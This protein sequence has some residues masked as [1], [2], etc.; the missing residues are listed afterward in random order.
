MASA[1][2]AVAEKTLDEATEKPSRPQESLGSPQKLGDGGKLAFPPSA[3]KSGSVLVPAEEIK[4]ESA[5]VPELHREPAVKSGG[6]VHQEPAVKSDWEVAPWDQHAGLLKMARFD[7]RREELLRSG[8]GGGI[9][10]FLITCAFRR[11]KSA[12]S[13]A[14]SILPKYLPALCARAEGSE[15]EALGGEKA[16]LGGGV[17]G[18]VVAADVAD[19]GK[20]KGVPE[21]DSRGEEEGETSA[22]RQRTETGGEGA[23]LREK[24]GEAEGEKVGGVEAQG[25]DSGRR[26]TQVGGEEG[27]APKVA[28]EKE[29]DS[30]KKVSKAEEDASAAEDALKAGLGAV[31]LGSMGITFLALPEK[32][33][34]VRGSEV[35]CPVDVV[36]QILKDIQEKKRT[37]L[38]WCQRICPVQATCPTT[39][40]HLSATVQR[41]LA[42]HF[43]ATPATAVAAT[44][45]TPQAAA[46]V[47]AEEAHRNGSETATELADTQPHLPPVQ[48]AV[49][50]KKRGAEDVAATTKESAKKDEKEAGRQEGDEGSLGKVQGNGGEGGE[51]GKVGEGDL[52]LSRDVVIRTVADA[53][54]EAAGKQGAAAN[55]TDPEFAI[56]VEIVPLARGPPFCAVSILPRSMLDTKPRLAVKT[57]AASTGGGAENA[58]GNGSAKT[59]KND[60][61]QASKEKKGKGGRRHGKRKRG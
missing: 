33:K 9:Q 26:F 46:A 29:E 8:N 2:P 31:K 55:L 40:R 52:V 7:Y 58:G 56:V 53:V 51:E 50:F 11:E 5:L 12:T 49:A 19:V 13:E 6:D 44:T 10:G 14:L 20:G 16:G 34:C 43:A 60:S 4:S 48:F 47:G 3:V 21:G 15:A 17:G 42:N 24:V 32:E 36:G 22:K 28:T 45:T 23:A 25:E 61:E 30:G 37:G 41:L 38:K 54:K 35:P 1:A 18:A 27:I 39:K 57:V 59:N